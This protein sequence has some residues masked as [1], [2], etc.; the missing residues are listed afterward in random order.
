MIKFFKKNIKNFITKN[1]LPKENEKNKILLAQSI[2]LRNRSLNSINEIGDVEFS[3]FSQYGEDGIIDWLVSRLPT[4]PKK[5]VEFGVEDYRESNTRLLLQLRNWQGLIIDGS[6]EF[7]QDIMNQDISWRHY[8]KAVCKYITKEN[9][10]S[11]IEKNNMSDDI[12]LLSIDIDGNDYHVWQSI[13]VIKPAIVVIEYNAVFGDIHSVTVPYRPDFLRNKAH[14]STLYFGASLPA[15]IMLG[16]EKGYTFVGTNTIGANAFFIR[17]DLA[18]HITSQIKSISAYPSIFR[19]SRNHDGKLS[20]LEGNKRSEIIK[21][22]P[23]YDIKNRKK[24]SIDELRKIYSSNWQNG[25]SKV[26]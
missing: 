19:E 22:C 10:N 18:S 24:T 12:G 3:C 20:L 11:L 2:A 23:L 4:I 7:I 14:F 21:N 6:K 15:L 1:F 26:F 16:K 17:N 5:F 8:V 13:N 25:N 9:I